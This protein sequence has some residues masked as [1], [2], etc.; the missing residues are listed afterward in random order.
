M[1]DKCGHKHCP[2]KEVVDPPIRIFRDHFHPQIVEIIRPIEIINRHHC[3][4][5]PK[6]IFTCTTVEEDC[7][8]VSTSVRKKRKK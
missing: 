7:S 6:H 2:T 1:S 3:F 8:S 4:P 5:V